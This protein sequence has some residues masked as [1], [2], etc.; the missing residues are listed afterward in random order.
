MEFL[1]KPNKKAPIGLIKVAHGVQR[2]H[3]SIAAYHIWVCFNC[4]ESRLWIGKKGGANLPPSVLH[5]L[6]KAKFHGKLKN[7]GG[8]RVP[9]LIYILNLVEKY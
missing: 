7:I 1:V 6:R 2:L 4:F 8:G 3:E 9:V 5:M